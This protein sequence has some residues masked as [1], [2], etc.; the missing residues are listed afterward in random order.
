VYLLIEKLII[1]TGIEKKKMFLIVLVEHITQGMKDLVENQY[2]SYRYIFIRIE[3]HY[4]TF[5]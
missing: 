5:L 4:A 2:T 1:D 3:R